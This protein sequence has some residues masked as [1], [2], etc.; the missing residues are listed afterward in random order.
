M[1]AGLLGENLASPRTATKTNQ[2]TAFENNPSEP[3]KS[4][5]K[6]GFESYVN[7]DA[8]AP[9]AD[10]KTPKTDRAAGR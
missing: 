4:S 7:K 5:S 9:E 1:I 6:Q 8:E 10:A 2:N 3:G